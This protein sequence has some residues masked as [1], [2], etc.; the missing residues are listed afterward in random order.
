MWIKM[1]IGTGGLFSNPL[2]K[3]Q[4]AAALLLQAIQGHLNMDS[5]NGSYHDS[6]LSWRGYMP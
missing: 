6:V 5:T 1:A 4:Q 3:L 2:N